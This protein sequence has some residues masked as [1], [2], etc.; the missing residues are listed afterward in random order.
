M[1]FINRFI[2]LFFLFLIG[3]L[4]FVPV[5]FYSQVP[6]YVN[7]DNDAS[8]GSL[9]EN[10]SDEHLFFRGDYNYP[11]FE[12]INEEGEPEGF[13]IDIVKAVAR[14][15][16]R[17]VN[18]DLGPWTEVRDQLERGE[19]DAI[20]GMYRTPERE[21][22]VDFSIPHSVVSYVL[23][24]R[25]GSSI[26]SL[27]DIKDKEIIV[28]EGDLGHDYVIRKNLGSSV[29]ALYNWEDVLRELSRGGGD[30][31]VVSMLQGMKLKNE[32]GLENIKTVGSP[33]FQARYCIAVQKGR[34]DLLFA[35]NEALSILKA[36][37]EYDNI[38]EKWFGVR[39]P[40]D[41]LKDYVIYFIPVLLLAVAG[42]VWSWTLRRSVRQ[43]TEQLKEELVKRKEIEEKQ[44]ASISEKE[45]LL[46]EIHHRVK[47]NLNV[48]V[49]LLGLQINKEKDPN[50]SKSLE[51]A[52]SRIYAIALIHELLYSMD[53]LANIDFG[54]YV[55]RLL[56][57]LHSLYGCA[58]KKITHEC[59]IENVSLDIYRA[60]PCGILINEIITNIYKHA[61][62]EKDEGVVKI[63]FAEQTGGYLLTIS[64]DGP[65]LPEES[66]PQSGT[67]LGMELIHL[68]AEKQLKGTL[69][70]ISENGLRYEIFIPDK[71]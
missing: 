43:K 65:G 30:V 58:S 21:K 16:N 49:S 24:V 6:V 20:T 47:N 11:P 70:I 33:L 54:L 34:S 66:V 18:I 52:R 17:K 32:L 29:I 31:A 68:L 27:N 62:N 7:A 40:S 56:E 26:K 23:F 59:N 4:F 38:Y 60:V 61:F 3:A 48:I 50:V 8:R 63:Y 44:Q 46:K 71:K 22:L 25:Y 15:M 37:G 12:F 69:K 55:D 41:T 2:F 36:S 5:L 42:F 13:N 53:D 10:S 39:T 35:V 51:V 1:N 28:Q 57:E 67:S 19:I 64:D 14:K 9:N 45:V